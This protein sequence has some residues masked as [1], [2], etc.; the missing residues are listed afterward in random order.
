MKRYENKT[1]NSKHNTA[2]YYF[3]LIFK[4]IHYIIPTF[5]SPLR[6]SNS[7]LMAS[8]S[9]TMFSVPDFLASNLNFP[10]KNHITEQ[11]CH[12]QGFFFLSQMGFLTQA[13]LN[14]N[15]NANM[16]PER[17]SAERGASLVLD[18]SLTISY[19]RFWE[20][21]AE[22]YAVIEERSLCLDPRPDDTKYVVRPKGGTLATNTTWKTETW[23]NTR[24]IIFARCPSVAF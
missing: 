17:L 16:R 14:Q 5:K 7:T 6:L 13:E 23:N 4:V 1:Y 21:S 19:P 20:L 15:S 10:L 12:E 8:F 18:V 3:E 22:L 24:W 9:K 11:K 2:V